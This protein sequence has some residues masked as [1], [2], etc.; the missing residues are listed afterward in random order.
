MAN[1]GTLDLKRGDSTLQGRLQDG[2]LEGPLRISERGRPQASLDYRDGELHGTSTLYHPNGQVSAQLPYVRGRLQGEAR[3]FAAE[4]WLQRRVSYRD[5]LMHGEACSYLADGTLV[6]QAFYREGVQEGPFR[7][8]HGNGQLAQEARYA[9][10]A[11]LDQPR[12][13]AEDGRPLD[14]NG[15]PISRLRWWLGSRGEASGA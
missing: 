9:K 8:F 11:P 3:F 14:D 12:A 6:E 2:A 13:Y 4:G 15:K 10:G 1:S 5:G 7:R